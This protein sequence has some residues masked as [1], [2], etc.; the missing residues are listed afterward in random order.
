M[1][2]FDDIIFLKKIYYTQAK[3]KPE[4]GQYK[5]RFPGQL[6][7]KHDTQTETFKQETNVVIIS[8]ID[9]GRQKFNKDL[10]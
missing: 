1:K 3:Y 6:K 9:Q 4:K 7:T 8:E 10:L 2:Q 5:T